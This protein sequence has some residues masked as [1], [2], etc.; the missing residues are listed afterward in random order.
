MPLT[1]K[2]K[3]HWLIRN[4]PLHITNISEAQ[5]EKRPAK[6]AFRDAGAA[7]QQIT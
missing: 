1:Q 3:S 6:R 7:G 2:S 4:K 5:H